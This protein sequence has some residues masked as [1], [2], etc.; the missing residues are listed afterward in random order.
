M[1]ST[2]HRSTALALSIAGLFAAVPAFAQADAAA[3]AGQPAA[4]AAP[5]PDAMTNLIRLLVAKGTLSQADGDALLGQAQAEAAAARAAI[6]VPPPPPPPGAVRVAHVPEAVRAQIRDEIRQEIMAQAATEGWVTKGQAAPEWTRKVRLYGDV[7][8]RSQ[9]DLYS[10]LNSPYLIDFASLNANGPTPLT[11]AADL[12]NV[13]K[14]NSTQDRVNRLRLR[15][16]LG[17]EANVL[18]GVTVGAMVGT[19]DDNSPITENVSLGGGLAK[20]DLWLDTAFIKLQP[21]SWATLTFGRFEN[22]FNTT[23]ML[24]DADL[25]FDGVAAKLAYD[26]VTGNGS[27]VSLTGGA[28]PIDYGNSNFPNISIDKQRYPSKWL[29]AGELAYKGEVADGLSVRASAGFHSFKNVQGKLSQPCNMDFGN[30]CSTDGLTPLS[31][32][33]GNTVFTMRNHVTNSTGIYP[34][35]FGLKFDYDILDLNLAA[36]AKVS[37]EVSARLSGNY[38]KNLGFHRK[39]ICGGEFD[40]AAATLLEPYNNYGTDGNGLHICTKTNPASFIGG[41]TAWLVN[42]RLGHDVVDKQGSWSAFAEYRYVESDAVLDAYTDSDFHLGG[43]NAKGYIL[44]GEYGLRDGLAIGA[45]WLS[46]NEIAGERL[47]IDV[48]Q[49]DLRARF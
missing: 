36:T 28:F 37:D 6:P 14:I 41:N 40:T 8:V 23:E 17:I 24:Y 18:E 15:A 35:V 12:A 21:K 45:R 9:S 7:R 1:R 46:S 5:S 48:L 13:T 31:L 42:A 30:F 27:S 4:A 43:T 26:G 19:G 2:L 39:D 11:T 29:F 32:R 47:A 10:K 16:R 49:I 22:P 20:R 33:K 25:R 34:Q 38:V 3:S 44:G